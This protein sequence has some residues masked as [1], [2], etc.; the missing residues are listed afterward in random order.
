MFETTLDI[1][2]CDGMNLVYSYIVY[3]GPDL[4]QIDL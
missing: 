1:V 3:V 4:R 2:E